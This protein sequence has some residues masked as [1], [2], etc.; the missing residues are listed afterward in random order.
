[1]SVSQ[2]V[3]KA[4]AGSNGEKRIPVRRNNSWD[5]LWRR[6]T[7][8]M[9]VMV[10]PMNSIRTIHAPKRIDNARAAKISS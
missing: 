9:P 5:R 7:P 2:L 1:M 10:T 8:P 4:A 6:T 3:S